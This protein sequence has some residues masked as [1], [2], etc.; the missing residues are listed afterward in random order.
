MLQII[1]KETQLLKIKA[2]RR[3][4]NTEKTK[5]TTT[6][7]VCRHKILIQMKIII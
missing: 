1:T 3:I 7:V 2:Q 6:V 4:I 5:Q